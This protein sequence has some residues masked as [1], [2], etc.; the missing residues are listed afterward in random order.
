MAAAPSCQ[1]RGTRSRTT[2]TAA[3][4]PGRA[5]KPCAP[6]VTTAERSG[7]GGRDLTP[8]A[9]WRRRCAASS[10]SASASRQGSPV[11][12]P[13]K[14]TCG[15]PLSITSRRSA[16][17]M[18]SACP[19]PQW[20]RGTHASARLSATMPSQVD[21]RL[22]NRDVTRARALLTAVCRSPPPAR[23]TE[24]ALANW[25]PV[26]RSGTSYRGPRNVRSGPRAWYSLSSQCD[27]GSA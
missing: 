1:T 24:M 26:P 16:L 20:E 4:A 27:P 13:P 2:K 10:P 22:R 14:S 9:A 23:M 25:H 18:L 3:Q 17:P 6:H 21:R 11:A 5:T 8:A 7:N 12:R 15:A 19:E